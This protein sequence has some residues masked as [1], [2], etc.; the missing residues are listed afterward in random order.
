MPA[1][2]HGLGFLITAIVSA[3]ALLVIF[4]MWWAKW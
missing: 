3:L 4:V 1:S 2:N